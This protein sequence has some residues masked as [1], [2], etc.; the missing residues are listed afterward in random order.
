MALGDIVEYLGHSSQIP[1][2]LLR[3]NVSGATRHFRDLVFGIPD[4]FIPGDVFERRARASDYAEPTELVGWEEPSLTKSIVDAGASV[5]LDP[6]TY[7]PGAAVLRGARHARTAAGLVPGVEKAMSKVRQATGNQILRPS[8]AGARA[9][10]MGAEAARTDAYVTAAKAN[11]SR[12]VWA[13][14]ALDAAMSDIANDIRFDDAGKAQRLSPELGA[15]LD[16]DLDDLVDALVANDTQRELLSAPK[17]LAAYRARARAH[18]AT[19]KLSETQ[20]DQMY[21]DVFGVTEEM[22]RESFAPGVEF[23]DPKRKGWHHA[24]TGDFLTETELDRL[25]RRRAQT[26]MDDPLTLDDRLQILDPDQSKYLDLADDKTR[27][28]LESDLAA[29]ERTAL[30]D[31]LRARGY[32]HTAKFDSV[33]QDYLK[34][35][36]LPRQWMD[37]DVSASAKRARTIEDTDDLLEVLNNADAPKMERSAR[38]ALIERI[39]AQGAATRQALLG[40]QVVGD[41]FRPW[42]PSRKT[43]D[44]LARDPDAQLAPAE[45]FHEAVKVKLREGKMTQEEADTLRFLYDGPK[46]RGAVMQSLEKLSRPFKSAAV[47]GIFIPRFSGIVRNRLST[48]FQTLGSGAPAGAAQTQ[49]RNAFPDIVGSIITD[50]FGLKHLSRDQAGRALARIDDAIRAANG[51]VSKAIEQLRAAGKPMLADALDTGVTQGGFVHTEEILRDIE[52]ELTPQKGVRA[53]VRGKAARAPQRMFQGTEARA[54]L[55]LFLDSRKAGKSAS[56]AAA[57]VND[58]LYDYSASSQVNRDLR[59][60]F[61][62]VQ[63]AFQAVPRE[64]K[65]LLV[66][67]PWRST[68]VQLVGDQPEEDVP[69]WIDEQPH[70][71]MADSADGRANYAAGFGFPLEAINEIPNLTGGNAG[72]ELLDVIGRGHPFVKSVASYAFN[73]DPF[74]GDKYGSYARNPLTGESS[75]LGQSF[76][77]IAQTGLIQPLTTPL[78]MFDTLTRDDRPI[79]SR[80]GQTFIGPRTVSADPI[81]SEINN[82]SDQLARD[83]RVSEFTNYYLPE[84][85]GE[86]DRVADLIQ[87]LSELRQQARQRADVSD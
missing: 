30:D 59:D 26:L 56:E 86:D 20:L 39:P 10:A 7:V 27:A 32:A 9:R 77:Q 79:M 65:K 37:K 83:D 42:G 55:L 5:A 24:E 33:G 35:L 61:P 34:P 73:V 76:Q 85:R 49:A 66:N 72:S 54:R 87:R 11:L 62:F 6:L 16:S 31:A 3:G 57:L 18:P 80:I 75:E 1:I 63:F 47:Y 67:S 23:W 58:T 52:H 38:K 8:L 81:W 21:K 74:T 43:R 68:A 2:N 4:A 78:Q 64:G 19:A 70:L 22:A 13:D 46:K 28:R 17:R 82:V 50:G 36:H 29:M 71:R 44:P 60:L 41:D 12:P 15:D 25:V 53:L 45:Q 51:N 69:G 14:D 84:W 40:R 48:V